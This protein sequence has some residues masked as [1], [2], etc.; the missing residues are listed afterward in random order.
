PHPKDESEKFIAMAYLMKH[1]GA[2]V[3][4]SPDGI[5]WTCADSPFWKTQL[6]FASWGDDAQKQMLYDK[7]KQK[8][9]VY[10]RVIPQEY[11][12]LVGIATDC[13]LKPV[14][15]YYRVYAYAESDDLRE[16]KNFQPVLSMDADDPA[17]TE[18]YYFTCY[19][20]GQVYVGYMSVFH[21]RYPQ[22]IDVQL[23]TSR[24]GLHWNRVCRGQSFIPSGPLGYYD[25]MAHGASQAEPIIVD[26]TV[27]FYYLACNAVHD[28]KSDPDK[29]HASTVAL[30]TF[31]RDR[32]ASLETGDPEPCRLVTKPFTVRHPKL[33]LNA[34]TWGQGSI[35]VEAL[36]RDWQLLPGFTE[37]Q[38]GD[39]QGDALD[40]PVRWKDNDDLGKLVGQEIRLKFYMTRA[41]L[42]AMTLSDEDRKLGA[43]DNEHASGERMDTIPKF[44]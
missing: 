15:R 6:D 33:F 34:A 29:G 37:P 12:R 42:H 1:R 14:D 13:D 39:I 28:V 5:H 8:W 40:H 44:L 4:T 11:D 9:V 36:T 18:L 25:L 16:W 19:N 38:T 22:P 43:V 31:K 26:D 17:D 41:R 10:R 20:Y 32:F 7:A 35:R 27:Y 30:A 2:Y 3:C 21:L 24:D 23:A